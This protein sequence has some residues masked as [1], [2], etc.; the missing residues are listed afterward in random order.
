MKITFL[1]IDFPKRTFVAVL[2]MVCFVFNFHAQERWLVTPVNVINSEQDEIA[3]GLFNEDILF[4]ADESKDY[5]NDYQ[6]NKSQPTRLYSAQKEKTYTGFTNKQKLF[7]YARAIESGTACFDAEDS[8]LYFSSQQN[9]GKYKGSNLRIF[10]TRWDGK[11][12]TDPELLKFCNTI[13]AYAHPWYDPVQKVIVFSSDKPGGMGANDI[14]YAYKTA[15]GWTEPVNPGPQVNTHKSEIYPSIFKGDIYFASNGHAGYGGYDI[16]QT[17]KKEQWSAA[18]QMDQPF[19]STQD[20]VMLFYL[21]EDKAFVTSNRGGSVGGYDIFHC[22]R[23]PKKGETGNYTGVLYRKGEVIKNATIH[24][25]NELREII[26]ESNTGESGIFTMLNMPIGNRLVLKVSGVDPTFIEGSELVVRDEKGQILLRLRINEKGQFEFELLPLK[27]VD[28]G[29]LVAEDPGLFSIKLE[30]KVNNTSSIESESKQAIMIVDDNGIPVAVTQVKSNGE[31]IFPQVSPSST[32]RLRL[33]EASKADQI[34]IFDRTQSIV[35]PLLEAEATYKRVASDEAIELVDENNK[36]ISL[37]PE[38]VFVIN[39]IYFDYRSNQLTEEAKSQL[40]L[41][42]SILISN[43][44]SAIEVISHTDSRGSS[45]HNIVLSQN[46]A[47]SVAT[48]LVNIG[49]PRNRIS[50]LGIGEAEPLIICDEKK[51]C[52]EVDHS[53]NRRTEIRILGK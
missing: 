51:N 22:Q 28:F 38:D 4:S 19:N 16:F 2:A 41:L 50:T 39:R 52:S 17:R 23:I 15:E 44:H 31:F 47:K 20:D 3:C 6:W 26:L 43:P 42:A 40:A 13:W 9:F 14:W 5:L 36:K 24:V 8:T 48:Y 33:S 12:W 32:Y 35:L 34:V 25:Q 49:V 1:H 27:Y 11:K 37:A 53:L 7:P 18:I 46:R 10:S 30:G 29:A 21:N 45:E